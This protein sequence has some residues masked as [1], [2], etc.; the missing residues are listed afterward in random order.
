[1]GKVVNPKGRD[2]DDEPQIFTLTKGQFGGTLSWLAAE[3]KDE[4]Q[5]DGIGA[6]ESIKLMNQMKGNPFFL[7]VGLYRPHTPYVAPKKYFELYPLDKITLPVVAADHKKGVPDAAFSQLQKE[8]EQLTD[9][10]RK[11]HAGL[12]CEYQL[13]G[14][15]GG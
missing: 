1:M 11:S 4:E 14:C 3:G 7:A 2:K 6:T 8:E 5:T 15:A 10:L 13:Y 9:D 12:S